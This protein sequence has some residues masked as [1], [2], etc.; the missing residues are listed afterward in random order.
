MPLADDPKAHIIHMFKMEMRSRDDHHCEIFPDGVVLASLPLVQGEVIYGAYKDTYFFTPSAFVW[1]SKGKY[2]RLEWRNVVSCS[3]EHG[4][5]ASKSEV[6]LSDGKKLTIPIG[7]MSTGWSGRVGQLYHAM[8]ARWRQPIRD[9]NFVLDIGRFFAVA[10]RP[11]AIAPNWYP[12]HPG[13]TQM[14]AWLEELRQLPSEPDVFLVATD[15][16]GDIP[17]VQ[18][19]VFLSQD[20]PSPDQVKHF[21]FSYLGPSHRRTLELMGAIPAGYTLTSGVWD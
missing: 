5:G 20:P 8:I 1:R 4:S 2:H 3:T 15:Y 14:R 10:D 21:F 6:R 11:D 7:E 13:L 19:V 12:V 16:E 17:C 9:E 18:E